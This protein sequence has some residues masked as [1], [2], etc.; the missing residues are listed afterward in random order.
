MKDTLKSQY[1][2]AVFFLGMFLF[3]YPVLSIYNIPRT[4]FGIPLLYT[5]IFGFWILIIV[6]TLLVIRKTNRKNNA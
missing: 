1:L 6:V 3:N 2:L 5:M 4:L